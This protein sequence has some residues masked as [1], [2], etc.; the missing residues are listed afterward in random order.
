[1]LY[2]EY[3]LLLRG[4]CCFKANSA[5]FGGNN[6]ANPRSRLKINRLLY[7]ILP[8][9]YYILCFHLSHLD[10]F[11]CLYENICAP[12]SARLPSTL[13]MTKCKPASACS[14]ENSMLNLKGCI[15]EN[16]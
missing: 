12:R 9:L 3:W 16:K 1:M 13:G 11:S 7:L 15:S 2:A 4:G 6:M 10:E 14:M 8:S 5:D